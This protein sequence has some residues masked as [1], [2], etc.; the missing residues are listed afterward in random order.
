LAANPGHGPD[1][2]HFVS[3]DFMHWA[4]VRTAIW[5]GI[6]VLVGATNNELL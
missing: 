4:D 1:Y 2:G 5:N 6:L 3:K